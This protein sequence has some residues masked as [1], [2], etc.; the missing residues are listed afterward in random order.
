MPDEVVVPLLRVR[1]FEETARVVVE[2]VFDEEEEE[3]LVEWL[4]EEDLERIPPSS[5]MRE[6]DVVR[7]FKYSN[8]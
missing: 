6:I 8:F 4:F 3:E 2:L 5:F 1:L 7:F